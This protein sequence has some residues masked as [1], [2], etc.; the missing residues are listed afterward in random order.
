MRPCSRGI[1]AQDQVDK[2]RFTRSCVADKAHFFS[3]ADVRLFVVEELLFAIVKSDVVKED[4]T[5][6]N[7]EGAC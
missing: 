1:K 5:G 2:C 7:G 6:G 3:S 4:L